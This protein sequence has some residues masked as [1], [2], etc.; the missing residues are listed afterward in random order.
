MAGFASSGKSVSLKLITSSLLI[1]S[2]V[3]LAFRCWKV[4]YFTE[5]SFIGNYVS[6]VPSL[7]PTDNMMDD[8]PFNDLLSGYGIKKNKVTE[9][10]AIPSITDSESGILSESGTE[11][12]IE[13]TVTKGN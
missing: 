13:S 12:D 7:L 2:I 4:F 8:G 10:V 1:F 6:S 11:S 9:I 3:W 5:L